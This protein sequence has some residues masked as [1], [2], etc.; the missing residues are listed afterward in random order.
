M[1]RKKFIERNGATCINW[2]W[3]W[4]FVNEEKKLILF[5]A[6]EDHIKGGRA[7]IFSE[8]WEIRRDRRQNAWPQ[9]REHIRLLEEEGYELRIFKMVCDDLGAS[10]GTGPRKIKSFDPNLLSAKLV[11]E[12]RDWIATVL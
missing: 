5:G 3:S 8:N 7:H 11:R 9:S 10:I 4:S 12:G 1:S 2:Y 6:W